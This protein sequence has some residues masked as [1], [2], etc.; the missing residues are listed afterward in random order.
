MHGVKQVTA[1]DLS[2]SLSFPSKIAN[3]TEISLTKLILSQWRY[4]AV[5]TCN[6]TNT[7]AFD[8]KKEGRS[9]D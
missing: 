2:E 7:L 9:H 3:V 1:L 8:L 5:V 6:I 4:P